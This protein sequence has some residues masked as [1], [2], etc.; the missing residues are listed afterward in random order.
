VSDRWALFDVD[1][2]PYDEVFN[3]RALLIHTDDA[4]DI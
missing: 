1:G 4:R 3:Y 2:A